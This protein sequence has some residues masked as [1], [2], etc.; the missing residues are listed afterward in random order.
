[1]SSESTQTQQTITHPDLQF[2]KQEVLFF[3][4]EDV[5]QLEN[6]GMLHPED[7]SHKRQKKTDE[8]ENP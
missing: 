3:G 7:E 5:H 1:M 2:Q 8:G 4:L 6:I